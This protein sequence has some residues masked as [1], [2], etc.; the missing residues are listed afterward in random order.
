[1]K[2]IKL[3]IDERT[4]LANVYLTQGF[5]LLLGLGLLWLQGRSV[6]DVLK[7]PSGF[8]P[9][10]WGTGFA[11]AVL[12]ADIVLSRW[13]P[14][15]VADDGGI[16]RM[17]FGSR[18]LWHIALLSLV[19][20]VCEELLF[21]GAVQHWIGP[22]WTSILFA[23]LHIRYLKHWLMTGIIFS[24]SYGLG[25]IVLQTGTLWTAIF[26]HFMIDFIMG[27]IIRYRRHGV[28]EGQT[29]DKS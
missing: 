22:Y 23:V 28:S 9:L 5:T 11:L 17:L 24:I 7:L 12:L 13:V 10:L 4:L 16:N 27:M 2:K 25:W 26:A 14:E 20:A 1:M 29:N 3:R 8:E 6:V 21:R 15:E 18:P 19:V